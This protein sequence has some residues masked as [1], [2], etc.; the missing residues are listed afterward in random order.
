MFKKIAFA[1]CFAGASLAAQANLLTNGSFDGTT[2]DYIYNG[3]PASVAQNYGA[4]PT[5]PGSVAGW[6]GEFVSITS[7]SGPWGNPSGISGFDGSFGD[8]VAGVQGD[9]ALSQSVTLSAGTYQLSWFDANRTNGNY[10]QT[11]TVKLGS[12]VLGTYTTHASGDAWK[13]ESVTFTT[14]GGS[15]QQLTFVGQTQWTWGTDATSFI[16]NASLTA[17]PEPTTTALMMFGTL[18]LLARR[19][20]IGR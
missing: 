4:V 17:V 16:D 5:D 18:A 10:D 12:Q 3:T 11:Y 6:S 2:T 13:Q 1:A 19:R 14:A 7:G 8:Y 20:R 9:A 15:A